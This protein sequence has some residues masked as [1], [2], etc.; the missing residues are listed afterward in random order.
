MI[1]RE[2]GGC[3]D[4]ERIHNRGPHVCKWDELA[5]ANYDLDFLTGGEAHGLAI[6]FELGE[7]ILSLMDEAVE[8][9]A[10]RGGSTWQ[11]KRT[12][13]R[14]HRRSFTGSCHRPSGGWR[15]SRS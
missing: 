9:A 8:S 7:R 14:S 1:W 10:R 11:P 6:F 13:R 12:H 5:G 3:A 2:C 4:P 15:R